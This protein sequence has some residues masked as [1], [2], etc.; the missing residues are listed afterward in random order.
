MELHQKGYD[1]ETYEVLPVHPWQY[2]H[3]IPSIYK[4][5]IEAGDVILLEAVSMQADATSS[6]RTVSPIGDQTPVIKLAV[7]SQMT[8]TVRSISKQTAMNST[9]FTSMM[10]TV[11]EREDLPRFA[12]L[13]ETAGA[14][15]DSEDELKSRN[16]TML[17]RESIDA[18]LQED[19]IAIAG[20]SLY[21]ESPMSGKTILHELVDQSGQHVLD[22]FQQY[23]Q[24]V[25][26]GYMT[27][28]I[29][30]GIALEGHLQNS[31]PVFKNGRLS[32]FFFRDWGGPCLRT[33]FEE[34]RHR[35]GF[36]TR[37]C[38]GNE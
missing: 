5:E 19:E 26:P 9:V 35:R 15:F 36:C 16:L 17:I 34:A 13:N 29:K 31:L 22:F 12:P 32:R 20:M 7:N 21:A 3:A 28:M 2:E 24:T 11:M 8:S 6:F 23:I 37:F 18:H 1:P 14:A 27:L 38:V 4:E 10:K 25:I 30:Y 33:T